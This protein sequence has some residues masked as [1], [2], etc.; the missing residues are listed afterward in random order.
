MTATKV[1]FGGDPPPG[2]TT[3]YDWDSIAAELRAKPGEWGLIFRDDRYSLVAALTN[4]SI[5][6]L[7]GDE[8]GTFQART[9]NNRTVTE[10]D[11]VSRRHCELWLCFTPHKTTKR[12]GK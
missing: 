6:S 2:R 4:G 3:S 10:G 1:T 5:A 12:K 11:G 8:H 7:R 9:T